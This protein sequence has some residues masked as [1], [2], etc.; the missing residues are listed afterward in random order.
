MANRP[1]VTAESTRLTLGNQ[2]AGTSQNDDES[3]ADEELEAEVEK[4]EEEVKEMAHKLSSYRSTFPD[5]LRSGL[6]TVLASQRPQFPV[7]DRE[8]EPASASGVGQE[9][10]CHGESSEAVTA[11]EEDEETIERIRLIK[12][13]ISRI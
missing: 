1:P 7:L 8:S 12:E 3:D 9:A 6:A 4:L 2:Q 13:K 11:A 5:Q 10:G